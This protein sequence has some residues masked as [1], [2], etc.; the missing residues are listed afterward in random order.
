MA[1]R[2]KMQPFSS[3]HTAGIFADMSVDGPIIGTLV[4]IVDRAKNLPNRKTI[5]KQD[6]Y[7]AARLG[8]EA[9]KTTTDIRGGQTPKWDQELRFTVHDSA[10]YYQ[11][12]VS[13]FTDDKKTDLI[14]EAWIDLKGIIIYGGGQR[15]V[16]QNLTCRGKYA[17]EIRLEITFY[18][19]RPK[20]DKPAPRPKLPAPAEAETRQKTHLKRR[21][22][23]SDPVTGEAT[24]TTSPAPAPAPAPAPGP[25]HY[26]TPPRAHA[27][28]TSHPAFVPTQSPLQAMEY[29]TPSPA[30]PRQLGGDYH[31]PSASAVSLIEGPRH[32]GRSKEAHENRARQCED[33]DYSPK[34]PASQH[35]HPDVRSQYPP[36]PDPFDA[37]PAE[38]LRQLPPAT[39][40]RPPPPPVHRSRHNSTGPE[41]MH[42]SSFDHAPRPA[43]P[44]PMR[45]DVLK[46]E[47]HRNSLP[48][49][50]GRPTF[51]AYD[52]AP[53]APNPGHSQNLLTYESSPQRHHS[54]DSLYETPHRS[55][56]PTV[57][58]VPE[59]SPA[60]YH[61][62]RSRQSD[63]R[64]YQSHADEMD[65]DKVPSP[66][67]LN[68]SRS[69][70]ANSHYELS[71][72][73]GSAAYYGSPS[74][75]HSP[76]AYRDADTRAR[77]VSPIPPRDYSANPSQISY[78]S[79]SS[80]SHHSDHRNEYEQAAL[81]SSSSYGM[82]AVPLSLVP[83]IDPNLSQEISER[84]YDERRRESL[85][86][87]QHALVAPRGRQ[88]SEPVQPYPGTGGVPYE[89]AMQP[90]NR[91]RAPS[92]SNEIVPISRPRNASPNPYPSPQHQIRRKSV[93]PA[94]PPIEDR[95][96]S[97]LPFGPDSY[98]ALNP[99]VMSSKEAA[100][101]DSKIIT[102]DG[103]EIDPSDHLPM[104]SWAPEPEP[105]PQ[106]ASPEPRARASPAGAQPMPTSGKRQL[107][108]A[109]RP[110]APIAQPPAYGQLEGP[111][112]PPSGQNGGRS[113]LQKRVHRASVGPS[114]AA[115]SPLAPIS[116]DNYQDRQSPYTPT[117]GIQ[118][119]STWDYPNEN[120]APHYGSGPPLPAKVPLPIMSGANGGA[121]D[122]LALMH[123]MQNIDIGAGRSRR[124]GGH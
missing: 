120:H 74:P 81:P 118:R 29:H 41:G 23:P 6:P 84:I 101:Y 66:A 73:P 98:D 34:P 40:D 14:G 112:T 32:A 44:M 93:S 45:H 91:Y 111:H 61:S 33:R 124:R 52:S 37:D 96:K 103:R 26:Q 43:Q 16:W 105:K 115:S 79:Q 18:D 53:P 21:P 39:D 106:Q 19:S 17:G 107:R 55:M 102:H 78:H 67:P 57:E 62:V 12:K 119:S 82:P 88:L 58:D 95:R 20:P 70:G 28:Q 83:G 85:T 54:Y 5:G 8:K 114:P 46:H 24:P 104:E 10:D 11:L 13:I 94:P 86:A 113:R 69:P 63:A 77:S 49:Y 38:D 15:D 68:L 9:K 72:S 97:D 25:D 42:R 99:N 4:A 7:C 48:S 76:G 36:V 100:D 35:E 110:S 2:V 75:G 31:S 71:R 1:T 116:P 122:Q 56:Q 60:G 108:I 22:L 109:A 87:S 59:D 117:R 64:N 50:P 90:Y 65:Y 89:M 92:H 47:A 80:T 3:P 51:R 30:G 121:E 27:R 123:E